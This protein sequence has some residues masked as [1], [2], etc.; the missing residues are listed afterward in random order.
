MLEA[1]LQKYHNRL[2]DAVAVINALIQIRKDID[3]EDQRAQTL[4]LEPE[5]LAFYDA[6]ATTVGTVYEQAFL[7][8]LIHDVWCRTASGI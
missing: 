2:I 4:N 5:E 1:T 3:S 7:R 8:D 6:V